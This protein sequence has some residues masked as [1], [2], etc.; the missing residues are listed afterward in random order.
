MTSL[1]HLNPVRL[2]LWCI[3]VLI[4]AMVI[5]GGATRL[6]DSGL[7]ITEWRPLLGA[8]P[9]L[10][11]AH[12]LDAFEK[13]KLIPEFQIQNR[14]M[15]LQ[16][17]KFIYWWEWSHRFLGRFIGV[18]F[19]LP[20]VYFIATKRLGRAYWPRLA[21]LFVIGGLQ[22]VLGWYMVASGLVTRVDVSQY[23][24]AAHLSLACLLF[25]AVVY[26]ALTLGR[27]MRAPMQPAGAVALGFIVLVFLQIAAGGFVA[28]LDAGHAAYDWPTMNGAMIPDG[29][30]TLQPLW[31][32][33]F[34]NALAV[35]FNHRL[36]AYLVLAVALAQAFWQRQ[37]TGWWVL[38]AVCV[39]V[40]L[41]IS[42]IMSH[43]QLPVA[44]MHQGGALVLLAFAIRHF[45]V[46]S[47]EPVA[48]LQ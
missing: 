41:G 42:T 45:V 9:P 34:D 40:L 1:D 12:W 3:A 29:L 48:N 25:A 35:Q 37:S 5:V 18:A 47:R 13:Y 4:F 16:D 2:W 20:L 38:A 19:L 22:G 32:N 27:A 24:L 26:S 10:N 8:I 15:S 14:D 43:V 46:V 36:I 23:R 21:V 31:H 6:T 30:N 44:L 39:Q 33:W 28:G 17:F 11:E 7:S